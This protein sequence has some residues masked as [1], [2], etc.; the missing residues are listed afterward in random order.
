MQPDTVVLIGPNQTKTI[1]RKDVN[2][3]KIQFSG[4]PME[5]DILTG[6]RKLV[7]V[8]SEGRN[9]PLCNFGGVFLVKNTD[10]ILISIY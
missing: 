6:L 1:K 9:F 10:F 7:I 4:A 3:M 2:K 5:I 8:D